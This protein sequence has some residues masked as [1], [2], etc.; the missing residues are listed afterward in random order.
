M[1]KKGIVVVFLFAMFISGMLSGMGNKAVDALIKK[2]EKAIDPKGISKKIKSRVTKANIFMPAQQMKMAVTTMHQFPDKM[3]A[4]ISIPQIME[5]TKVCNGKDAW[6]YSEATGMR[7]ITGKELGSLKFQLL[8]DNPSLKMREVFSEITIPDELIKVDDFKCY[9]MICKP[10]GFDLKP[11]VFYIDNTKYLMRKMEMT[12]D[13]QMG[14]MPLISTLNKYKDFGDLFMATEATFLQMGMK[15]VVTLTDVKNNVKIPDS[16]FGKP[17]VEKKP[18][19]EKK[20]A[21]KE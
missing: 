10:R 20:S 4:I 9:K 11:V 18:L 15:M 17:T 3:K 19:P 12:V 13:T 14:S 21:V 5:I 7:K 8:M 6:E 1:F 2:M 16:E